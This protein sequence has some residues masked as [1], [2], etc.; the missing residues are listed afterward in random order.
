[1][2]MTIRLMKKPIKNTART[3]KRTKSNSFLPAKYFKG[4][5]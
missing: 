5:P 1:M 4:Q 2:S 3:R